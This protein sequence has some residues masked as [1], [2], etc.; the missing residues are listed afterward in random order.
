MSSN[1]TGN[2]SATQSPSPAPSSGNPPVLVLPSDGDAVNAAAFAQA[3]K[4][5]ADYVAYLQSNQIPLATRIWFDHMLYA[6]SN[7]PQTLGSPYYI[8]GTVVAANDSLNGGSGVLQI[9]A[10]GGSFTG[11]YGW[12]ALPSA[13]QGDFTF[14]ARARITGTMSAGAAASFGV[15]TASTGLTFNYAYNSSPSNWRVAVDTVDTAA[16]G[17]AVAINSAYSIFEIKRASNVVTFKVNG[18]TLHTIASYTSSLE[19]SHPYFSVVTI[20]NLWVDWADM[21]IPGLG[22]AP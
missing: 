9:S 12:F 4:A 18:V 11:D 13:G 20:A 7:S 3:Y 1:Y 19:G 21:V 22:F 2:A 15:V 6:Q 16:N 5:L 10:A 14:R 17:T 8:T